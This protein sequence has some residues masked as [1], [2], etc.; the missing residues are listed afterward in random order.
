MPSKDDNEI[1]VTVDR[2]A[3]AYNAHLSTPNGVFE[4]GTGDTPIMI[5][6]PDIPKEL[7]EMISA[8]IIRVERQ[9]WGLS[10]KCHP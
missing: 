10:E 5:Q 3:I 8:L 1:I 9:R 2:F 6:A 4:F 7:R